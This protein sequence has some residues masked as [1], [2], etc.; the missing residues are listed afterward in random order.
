MKGH[1]YPEKYL[2][3]RQSHLDVYVIP[4]FGSYN[5]KEIRRRVIDQWLLYLKTPEGKPLAGSTKNKIMCT[6]SLV[7]EELLDLDVLENNPIN[8]IRAFNTKP[9]KPRGVIDKIFMDKLFP[10]SIDELVKVWKSA[11]WAAM[12]MVFKDTGS[13]PGEVRALT[14]ADIDFDKRFIPFRKGVASGT[15]DRI[16]ETKTG[17]VKAGFITQQTVS[18]LECWRRHSPYKRDRDFIFSIDGKKPVSAV[19]VIQA[20]RRGLSNVGA[21]D[22][23]WTPYWLRHSFGTYQM[24]NLS[25]EEIMKLMGHKTQVITRIYQH[26]D[27][28]ILYRSAEKIKRKLDQLREYNAEAGYTLQA[29]Q[30]S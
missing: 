26:P 2:F 12:M 3:G 7:F 17:T 4:T 25:Q 13:R 20:F 11:M 30:S 21:A 1:V 14:W 18:T 15:A 10:D 5:P 19:A 22:K 28:E 29:S 9:V 6:M 27:N 16:K 23:P 8:G 24:A